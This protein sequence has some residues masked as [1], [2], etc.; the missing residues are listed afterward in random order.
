PTDARRTTMTDRTAGAQWIRDG[1]VIGRRPADN[2]SEVVGD[3]CVVWD[4][5]IE[6]W[7]MI[8]FFAP[9]GHGTSVSSDPSAA[10]GTWSDPTPLVFTNPELLPAG[11]GTHKPFVVTDIE[12]PN[13]ASFVDGRYWLV[14]VSTTAHD[15]DKRVQRAWSTSLAGP[16][17]LEVEDL[18]PRGNA[19]QFDENHADAV[20]GYW[21]QAQGR[22]I[23]YYMGY[24]LSPQPW[25]H[26]PYG[27]AIG[28]VTQSPGSDP[29]QHG[30]MLAPSEHP[31]H[32]ASGYL[33][34][35]Q[36]LDGHHPHIAPIA[37][38]HRWVAVLNASPTPPTR[39]GSLTSE[40]PAPSL[41]GLAFSD[42]E[43][44]TTGWHL[45]DQP[46]EWIDDIPAPALEAGEG[47]NLWR[48]HLLVTDHATRLF[49]N[50]GFYGQEQMFSKQ[51]G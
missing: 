23:Y 31:G 42:D 15:R 9:P 43:D 8:L 29:R 18:I 36:L 38:G 24:P 12:R 34:G 14:T 47:V 51:L 10:P 30:V 7:R 17:T 41:G 27:S 6:A 2:G 37:A 3:P 5:E 39:D 22:F 35:F 44:P 46:F 49:Y 50:S 32:W 26:S 4:P 19:G 21:S 33:G 25:A 28:V 16:W 40:E 11:G 13:R 1:L 48:H 20:S 45:A